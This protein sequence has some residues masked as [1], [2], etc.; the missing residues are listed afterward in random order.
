M[1]EGGEHQTDPRE[2]RC[3][4]GDERDDEKGPRGEKTMVEE[5]NGQFCG[6]DRAAEE[7]LGCLVGLGV[8]A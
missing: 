4:A 6:G 5:E 1:E 7:D 8:V 3:D 2:D